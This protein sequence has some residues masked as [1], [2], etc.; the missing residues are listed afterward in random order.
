[1][2]TQGVAHDLRNTA[3]EDLRIIAFFSAPQVEQHWT[4]EVWEPGDL[5]GHRA[6]QPLN[7]AHPAPRAARP[8]FRLLACRRPRR[9]FR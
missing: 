6:P 7:R 2:L 4:K 1:V 5:K 3:A 9:D 8:N